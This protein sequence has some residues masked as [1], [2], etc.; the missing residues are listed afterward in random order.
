MTPQEKEAFW[1]EHMDHCNSL[2]KKAEAYDKG[3]GLKIGHPIPGYAKSLISQLETYSDARKV[4][5]VREMMEKN[6]QLVENVRKHE[7]I[8]LMYSIA[9]CNY[10]A[11]NSDNC[12]I[13]RLEGAAR[14]LNPL[15]KLF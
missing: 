12:N 11:S 4:P 15:A 6:F 14:G 5:E 2:I 7:R 3:E 13:K 8:D 10:F 9:W 1:K